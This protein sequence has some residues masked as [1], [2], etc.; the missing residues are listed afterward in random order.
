MAEIESEHLQLR[1]FRVCHAYFDRNAIPDDAST[2]LSS[3]VLDPLV[4]EV[5]GKGQ[6]TNSERKRSGRIGCVTESS[7]GRG[8]GAQLCSLS[9]LSS[10]PCLG[11][12]L[13]LP[14]A[15]NART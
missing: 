8:I 13:Y 14:W 9:P 7:A 4:F 12:K 3:A 2:R 15:R 1:P 5:R 6:A 10:L 11:A